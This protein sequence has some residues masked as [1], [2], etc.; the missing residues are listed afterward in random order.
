MDQDARENV[1]NRKVGGQEGNLSLNIGF[2]KIVH[3][4][5]SRRF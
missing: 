2:G 3:V 1:D 5:V 4:Y